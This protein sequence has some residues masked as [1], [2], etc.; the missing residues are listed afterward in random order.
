MRGRSWRWR[1]PRSSR[2]LV[3]SFLR[4][5]TSAFASFLRNPTR[6]SAFL[7]NKQVSCGSQQVSCGMRVALLILMAVKLLSRTGC[8][9]TA[10]CS[11]ARCEPPQRHPRMLRVPPRSSSPYRLAHHMRTLPP[12]HRPGVE[13]FWRKLI[14]EEITLMDQ[15]VYGIV[16]F[17]LQHSGAAEPVLDMQQYRFW[18]ITEI[19]LKKLQY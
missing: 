3:I 9:I 17:R 13:L 6:T 14:L 18:H 11:L 16:E 12:G 8:K 10:R 2:K 1:Q 5:P 19:G 15:A 4:N 7:A